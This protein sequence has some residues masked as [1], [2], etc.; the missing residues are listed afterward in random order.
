MN[1]LFL[2]Y[3]FL[4]NDVQALFDDKLFLSVL[5]VLP[6]NCLLHD[7][8]SSLAIHSLRCYSLSKIYGLANNLSLALLFHNIYGT[9]S[10]RSFK[11]SEYLYQSKYNR[12]LIHNLLGEEIESLIYQYSSLDQSRIVNS[13]F[14]TLSSEMQLMYFVNTVEIISSLQNVST[15]FLQNKINSHKLPLQLVC[16][17]DR[18]CKN[19]RY[20]LFSDFSLINFL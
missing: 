19:L 9:A 12:S 11:F 10:L 18:F 20:Q 3:S 14:N 16:T 5:K 7:K 8:Y 1:S 6:T 2:K 13:P 15:N 17:S 4:S